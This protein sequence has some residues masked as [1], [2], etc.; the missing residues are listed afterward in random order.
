MTVATSAGGTTIVGV[1]IG[2]AGSHESTRQVA[3]QAVG[4]ITSLPFTGASGIMVLLAVGLLTVFMG[5]LILGL[6]RRHTAATPPP[7]SA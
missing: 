3:S 1:T 2:A 5:L 6:T 7:S 4:T